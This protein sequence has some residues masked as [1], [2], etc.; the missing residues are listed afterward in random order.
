MLVKNII[1]MHIN[2]P[3]NICRWSVTKCSDRVNLW[4][5]VWRIN[6]TKSSQTL[7]NKFPPEWV[8]TLSRWGLRS[9]GGGA[10]KRTISSWGQPKGTPQVTAWAT[11]PRA[12]WRRG[13]FLAKSASWIPGALQVYTAKPRV[14]AAL[15]GWKRT[16]KVLVGPQMGTKENRHK[17]EAVLQGVATLCSEQPKESKEDLGEEPVEAQPQEPKKSA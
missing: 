7:N 12:A 1:N 4:S 10:L 2:Y 3:W 15:P 9:R 5:Y 17:Y 14:I 16:T 6:L 13:S 8:P 11:V